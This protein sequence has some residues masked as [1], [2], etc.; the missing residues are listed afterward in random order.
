[1]G[2]LVSN[3]RAHVN[4][5]TQASGLMAAGGMAAV[6]GL[7]VANG[8]DTAGCQTQEA[9]TLA[10]LLARRRVLGLLRLTGMP[11]AALRRVVAYETLLPVATVLALSIGAA[12]YT[13]RVLI[14]GT[15]ARSI[16]WPA[17]SYY[18]VVGACLALVVVAAL[19]SARY[20]RRMLAGTTVRFE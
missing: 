9:I 18:A 10:S 16:G 14:T 11:H 20:G 19:A 2:A 1:M 8:A 13:A 17:G 6:D 15:S 4:G 7:S 12:V 5:R 3:G